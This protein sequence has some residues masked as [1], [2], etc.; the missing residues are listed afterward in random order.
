MVVY[1][2]DRRRRLTLVLLVITSLVLISLDERG[3]GLF[4]SARSTAQDVVAPMQRALDSVIDPVADWLDGLG[5]ATE[6]QDEN[7]RLRDANARL[8]A[9][10]ARAAGA[11]AENERFRDIFDIPR[12]ADYDAIVAEVQ[13]GSVDNFHRT[14]RINKGSSSDI[15]VDMPVIVGGASGGALVGRVASVARNSAVI[16]RIDDRDFS[17][18]AQLVQAGGPGPIGAV[19]GIPGSSELSF[20]LFDAANPGINIA[21][22]ELVQTSGG[23][24][25]RFPSG[26]PIGKVVRAVN[27]TAAAARNTR[28]RPIVDLD[29][30]QF[31]KILRA[32][33]ATPTP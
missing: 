22:G 17:A 33:G 26:L 13:I 11:V 21:T 5:R 20:D 6:L 29:R 23:E 7:Q 24:S 10:I 12:I 27:A 18:G 8:E 9:E 3:S 30:V 14:W 25:S 2:Q 1:R 19:A 16:Q 32:S 28:L 15:A 4:D 31:V